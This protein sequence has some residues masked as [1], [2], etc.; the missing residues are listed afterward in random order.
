MRKPKH[1]GPLF[2]KLA[3][4]RRAYLQELKRRSEEDVSRWENDGGAPEPK[5]PEE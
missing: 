2:D 3:E 1:P 4:L 5:E